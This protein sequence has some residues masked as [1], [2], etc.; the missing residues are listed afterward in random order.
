MTPEQVTRWKARGYALIG[1][2]IAGLVAAYHYATTPPP[3]GVTPP[4][5]PIGFAGLGVVFLII[6]AF[7]LIKVSRQNVPAA[8]PDLTGPQGKK[9]RLLVLI[10]FIALVALS[11]VNYFAPISEPL[12]LA[13]SVGLLAV[14]GTCFVSAGRTAR[15]LKTT[16]SVK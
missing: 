12:W 1:A 2:G 7:M 13:V 6:G 5:V 10:G 16:Q 14:T 11:A 15:K 3:E 4:I 8:T 9:V